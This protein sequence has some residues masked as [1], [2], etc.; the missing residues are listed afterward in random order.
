VAG[1][2]GIGIKIAH[3]GNM[4]NDGYA[5]VKALR[6]N[7]FDADLLI[8]LS[9]FGMGLPHWEIH[10]IEGDPYK[11]T[12]S[13]LNDYPLPEW[14]KVYSKEKNVF[15]KASDMFRVAR[16]YDILHCHFPTFNFIQFTKTPFLIYEAGFLRKIQNYYVNEGMK[17]ASPSF[18]RYPRM[19][20]ERLGADAYRKAECVTWTNTDMIDMISHVEKKEQV[21]IPFAIDEKRYAPRPVEAHDEL[22]LLNP[23]RQCWDVKGNDRVLRAFVRFIKAGYKAHLTLVDWGYVE[24]VSEAKNILSPVNEHVTWVAPMSKPKLIEAYHD[25]D[26]ILDQFILGGSGTTGYEAMSCGKPLMI[27]F[28]D[29][30]AKCYG[31]APPCVNVRTEDEILAGLVEM[32]DGEKRERLG[33]QGRSFVERHLSE[34]VVASKLKDVYADVYTHIWGN[35]R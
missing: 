4:A 9:D 14:I 18:S 27:Y 28:N 17:R 19:N 23:S 35:P 13:K 34:K 16:D 25:A 11:M 1:G 7:G 29:S 31:E 6:E 5:T 33:A 26:V 30:A 24:D 2:T 10:S 21:F 12:I 20:W 15:K 8:D 32:V 22:R 3:I